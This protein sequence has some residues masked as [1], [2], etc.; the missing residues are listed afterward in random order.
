MSASDY[1]RPFGMM[2]TVSDLRPAVPP[3]TEA[4]RSSE[5]RLRFLDRVG[6]ATQSLTDPTAVMAVTARL[7]GVCAA[8]RSP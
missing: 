7:L 5:E 3:D 6:E 8:S 2:D 1:T 4:L